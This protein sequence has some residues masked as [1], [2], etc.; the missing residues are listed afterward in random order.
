MIEDDRIARV[1][2]RDRR[3][4]GAFWYGVS[5]TGI[6]CRPSCPS[7]AAR[8]AHLSFHASPEAAR[9]AGFRPC[10][11]CNPDGLSGDAIEAA[12]VAKA[13]RLADGMEA[14]PS[15]ATLAAFAGLRPTQFR[16]IFRRATGLAPGAWLRARR[17]SRVRDGLAR[18]LLV[19]DAAAD[20][21][22]G[23]S[24][25]LHEQSDAALGMQP[26]R[27]RTG[28][29]GETIRVACDAATLGR[30]L[31]ASTARGLVAILLG[32]D[33]TSLRHEL[34][35]RFPRA[36]IDD[37]EPAFADTVV[38]VIAMVDDPSRG[39]DL[40]LDI[41]GT[42][43]Q[44]R[45]WAALRAT[46]A[47]E[48]LSYTG[49]AARIGAGGAVR[50]VA[51]ACAANPLAVAVPCH[52]VRRADGGLAGYAWGAARKQALLG[53][54]QEASRRVATSS[55]TGSNVDAAASPRSR[56]TPS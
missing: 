23:S 51:G 20:A 26:G 24:A 18:G 25:R 29:A 38:R 1:E 17:A 22:Y 28:G 44:Q 6:Y 8:A 35:R 3:A 52:R 12:L 9:R 30:V 42:A 15:V 49:L 37:A 21:G 36:R 34:Q 46:A 56:S 7:R 50:A 10:L 11:R 54:E 14:A 55:G 13:C 2:A 19:A 47:G 32:D 41:R 39:L 16:A 40:P 48:T 31:V 5:T 53:R 27:Y 43:F 4:D 45:V 33:D